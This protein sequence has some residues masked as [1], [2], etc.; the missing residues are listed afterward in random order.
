[1]QKVGS[2]TVE[3]GIIISDPSYKFDVNKYSKGFKIQD[4]FTKEKVKQGEWNGYIEIDEKSGRVAVLRACHSDLSAEE[5]DKCKWEQCNGS[6]GVDSGQ[7]GIYDSMYFR[8]NSLVG[9]YPLA[10]YIT[11]I[12]KKGEKWYSMCCQQ[13]YDENDFSKRAGIIPYGVVSSSGWGDGCYDYSVNI[14]NNIVQ[15]VEILFMYKYK[16]ED[17]DD[18]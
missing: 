12:D 13:T 18:E 16:K 9:D 8:D 10:K 14:Q 6:I 3:N 4:Y 7:A 2:F 5:L 17:S 15:A 1:M 11:N